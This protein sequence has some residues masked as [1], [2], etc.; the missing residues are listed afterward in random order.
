VVQPAGA[1]H[2]SHA[3]LLERFQATYGREPTTAERHGLAQQATLATRAAKHGP[4][5]EAEQRRTW[6]A[7][8]EVVLGGEA[9]GQVVERVI[10]QR[11]VLPSL[12]PAWA[13]RAAA[14][15]VRT[16]SAERAVFSS[17]HLRAEL[18][19]L[20]RTDRIPLQALDAAI[21]QALTVAVS[22]GLSLRL[23]PAPGRG[24]ADMEALEPAG[25]RRMD[26]SSVYAT[27]HTQL[28]TIPALLA[29]ERRILAAAERTDGHQAPA[30][31]IELA[32]LEARLAGR[33]LN[34]GQQAMV[35]EL[36]ASGRRMQVAIAP[37][38]TGKTT[39]LGV[40]ASAWADAGG[41][42]LGAAPSA[43]AASE[44]REAI[45]HPAV[46]LASANLAID[47]ARKRSGSEALWV[48]GV[49]LGPQL[50]VLVDEAGMAATIDLAKLI[51]AV[52][53]AGGSVR[54]VGDTAQLS[55]PAAGG[56]LHDLVRAHGAV[57]LDTPVRFADPNEAAA[58]LAIR[59]GDPDGLSFYAER[60]R[61]RTPQTPW[62]P[63]SPSQTGQRW[64]TPN[65]MPP[66]TPSTRLSTAG[67]PTVLPAATACCWPA[68][69]PSSPSSMPEPAPRA[70]PAP[71]TTA[72]QRPACGT[73][74]PPR[75]ATSSWPGTISMT[76]TSP[77][78]NGSRTATGS[79]S[80]P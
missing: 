37:A 10:S 60:G 56:I 45:A 68:T 7:Q 80:P 75:S 36:A 20:S 25:L 29:A 4:R 48:G 26:G 63:T 74:R 51:D 54:L 70:S 67:P 18:E 79:P 73:A 12:D 22:A 14:T 46:T 21:D 5:S 28:Y 39:A 27:A 59:A 76:C 15:A 41:T 55:S 43:V 11:A 30:G 23:E 64:L 57:R 13:S 47:D 49:P 72:T 19:R 17:H 32:F 34:D 33:P 16:V 53:A 77:P 65:T 69:T 1:D 8:A 62:G 61:I 2:T 42:V 9:A 66:A 31:L 38:G 58:T 44:L 35:R 24:P 78:P 6:R 3:Q 50:L 71:Q 52:T 40:L